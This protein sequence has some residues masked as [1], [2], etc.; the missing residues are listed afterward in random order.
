M[1]PNPHPTNSIEWW[2][3]YFIEHWDAHGGSDQTRHFM[4][5]LI[6]ELPPIERAFL[7]S[8]GVSILDWGCAFGEGVELLARSFPRST[9]TGLD[10]AKTAIEQAGR[11]HPGQR[12]VQTKDGEIPEPFDVIITSN[13]LEHFDNPIEVLHS[14]LDRCNSLYILLVP[15]DESPLSEY[16]RSGFTE[17]SFPTSI[18]GFGRIFVKRIDVEREYWNGQQLLVAYGSEAYLRQRPALAPKALEQEKWD[19]YYSSLP[20]YGADE[21]TQS[22]AVELVE[23]ISELLPNGGRILEAGC[24]GGWQSMALGRSGKFEVH[25]M[26]FSAEALRYARRLFEREGLTAEF[27]YGDVFMPGEPEY[28]LVFN[29][30]VL[31]HYTLDEQARFLRGMASRSRKYVLAMVPN[32]R[33]YWYWLWRIQKSINQ[34]WPFGKEVPLADFSPAFQ[35]SGLQ[36]LG[37]TFM[38]EKWADSF[39]EQVDGISPEL[40]EQL[41]EITHSPLI[42]REQK[43]YLL[44][45]LG[46]VE[47]L[48]QNPPQIWKP[49]P[50]AG[51]DQMAAMHAA[52]A[53]ALA[54]RI[55]EDKRLSKLTAQLLKK[56]RTIETL[57]V[58]IDETERRANESERRAIDSARSDLDRQRESQELASQLS[59][60]RTAVNS[61]TAALREHEEAHSIQ[62]AE[63]EKLVS[64]LSARLA[65]AQRSVDAL[66]AKV[67]ENGTQANALSTQLRDKENALSSLY[68][69]L[70]Q[71]QR[72]LQKITSSLGWRLLTAYGPIKYRY[73]LPIYRILGLPPY[74]RAS[75]KTRQTAPDLKTNIA[76]SPEVFV[77]NFE[78]LR[79]PAE[80]SPQE[81]VDFREILSTKSNTYDVV[82]FPII[83]WDFRFQ[84]PQQLMTRFAS[85]GHRVF[86]LSQSFRASGEPYV[87]FEKLHNVYEVSLRGQPLNVYTDSLNDRSRDELFESLDALRRDFALGATA[88]VVQLPFWWPLVNKT[89]DR[90]SWPVVYDCMDHHA[91]FSTNRPTMIGQEQDLLSSADLVVASSSFLRAEALRKNSSVVVVRNGCEYEHFAKAS[92]WKGERPAIGY[93]GAIADWFD[94]DLVADLAERRPDWDFILV[95][96]TFSADTKRLSRLRNVSL[97]GEQ[98]YSTIP[99]WLR[100]F[101][102]AILPFKRQP[103]TE[104]TNPVK[105]YEILASGKPLISVPIPEMAALE[106]LVGLASTVEEF[107]KQITA[108]LAEEGDEMAQQRRNFAKEN[109]WE[110]RY[111]A[112][113][114]AVCETFAKASIIIVTFNSLE[115]NRL[116]IES[117]FARTDWPNFE[118]IVVDNA[119]SDETPV[120]LRDCEKRFPN[121]H[122]I[123]NTTNLG[124]A[125]ANNIGLEHATG[126]YLVLLNND[127]VVTPGWLSALIRHLNADPTIGLVGPVTNAIA[128]EARIEVGYERIE[129]MESWAANYIR[130]HDSEVFA[131][132]MLAMFCV[133]MKRTLFEQVGPLD[134]RFAVGM[135]EDDDYCRRIRELG[136]RLVCAR[137]SFIH[138]WQRA[139]FRLL[140]ED[141]YLRVYHENRKKYERK[142]QEDDGSSSLRAS[143]VDE[144]YREQLSKIVERVGESKGA[145]IF[146]PSIGWN[147]HLFQRPHHL[148]RTFAANGYVAIFDSSNSHDD[149]KGFKEIEPNLFLFHGPD[150]ILC[151]IPQAILW[152]F[153]YN[154]DRKDAYSP[155]A[156]VV[157]DWIDDLDVFP[158]DRA[159]LER[160]HRR[161]L[162]ESTVVACVARQL[163]EQA[164]TVRPDALYLPNGVEYQR[165]VS[166][167]PESAGDRDLAGFLRDGKPI[168]GYYGALAEWFDYEL[169]DEV[170]RLRPDWNFVLIGQALD[171]SVHRHALT[172]RA[173][174]NWIGPRPYESLPGYLRLFDVATIP[175]K[176]NR[177]TEATSP[178]KL[179][180]YMAGGK[181]II[182]TPMPEC[183]SFPFVNIVRNAQEFALMLDT[184]RTQ[185]LDPE[186]RQRLLATASQ[187]SWAARVESVID[188][189]ELRTQTIR[190]AKAE[191]WASAASP[192]RAGSQ[193][194]AVAAASDSLGGSAMVLESVPADTRKLPA[195]A[196]AL[197]AAEPELTGAAAR[198]AE[199]FRHFK[200]LN[201]ARLF[202]ALARHLAASE[203]DP[204]L[205]MYFEFAITCNERG[206]LAANL[207]QRYTTLQG[208]QYLDVGCAYGGFLVAFAEQGAHVTGMDIDESLLRL[209]RTNLQDNQLDVSLVLADA[210]R[211]EQLKEFYDRV[212][213][214]TCNDVIEHV[215]DPQLLLSNLAATLRAD[216]LAYFEIPNSH[217]PRHVLSDG[218]YQL[219]GITLLDYPDARNY[220][221]LHAPGV[222]YGVRHY[223]SLEQYVQMFARAGLELEVL[224]SNYLDVDLTTTLNDI[225]ELRDHAGAGLEG[226]PQS[227]R[228]RVQERLTKYFREVESCPRATKSEQRA[229]LLRYGMGFWRVL[230]RKKS[231]ARIASAPETRPSTS[232][233]RISDKK[234]SSIEAAHSHSGLCNVCGQ[235][236]SFYYDDPALYRESLVCA[237]CGTTSRYRSIARGILRAI[238][239]LTGIEV[240]SIANLGT[241]APTRT[242]KIYDT[243]ASFYYHAGAYPIPDLLSECK[244]L[245]VQTSLFKPSKRLGKLLGP[246]ITNQNLEALTFADNSFDIVVT[247]D[248]ME[249]VRLDLRAH[250]EVRR[251]LKPGGIYLFTVPH[252]RDRETLYR[253][254]VIDPDDPAKDI[255]LTEKEYHGD[256]NSKDGRALSYRSYGTDLDETLRRLGFSVDYS[257]TDI[258]L[259]GIMNTELFFCRLS[260]Q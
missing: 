143:A 50:S 162:H 67:V 214:I 33:C 229:F 66:S 180:E 197:P 232:P 244:W 46:S 182:T 83:D 128:N 258:P 96:S 208:K 55:G 97:P 91:G 34:D 44:A 249:H 255:F 111:A 12:F 167:Y 213:L 14:H 129:E 35:A 165:F 252:F 94:S 217:T 228:T 62:L 39:V 98:H 60:Q 104:A 170:A 53:D 189:L 125:P 203:S 120:Y 47:H 140:G 88:A 19:Q 105:A 195:V 166:D 92:G 5:R 240:P 202:N 112:L 241:V 57:T 90:F 109:T 164:L 106:P 216:G 251:V 243:Q 212:D 172:G 54:L 78:Q 248:V 73:L 9:V 152:A 230:G 199:H 24:G 219:F 71:K 158:H 69:Q 186:F 20:L 132:Q 245:E 42:P 56:D 237:E 36:F 38:G 40:K 227:L 147:I 45:G 85:D 142:W 231:S 108:A 238:R 198:I 222:S 144:K 37:Q 224:E 21:A 119:S 247:S 4:E 148:A 154:L 58:R 123:L 10:F 86:Y 145:V 134:E 28:D 70:A 7:N 1:R 257:K 30:G 205:A 48:D 113:A 188:T 116:C 160:N 157:Y 169:L 118:V 137:D 161:G 260:K 79:E 233:V 63:H 215:E 122:V 250:Q 135:F 181:P 17:A 127:T 81:F 64:S 16:H 225:K 102:V 151:E 117:V 184:A 65:E 15:Y 139:S 179:Y 114:P 101:D 8:A 254:A 93:Y 149:V 196:P 194:R 138:H 253:V 234:F 175:F 31:E 174:V 236:T 103:L 74:S 156:H 163:H 22:F 49:S 29:A 100:K 259:T 141:E 192:S 200:T 207:L 2:E 220:Y 185:A 51:D 26:D 130:H 173:N 107:E 218:H 82:C 99:K 43:S 235:E 84:R 115:L 136:Y 52:L 41:L 72:E 256:A 242:L 159:L 95:G 206:R 191:S 126:E 89:R 77:P 171:G 183:Q 201:N 131:I 193:N 121:L 75:G 18:G 110:K 27:I 246:K 25:L 153:P 61:L 23:H 226:V 190:P 133:A 146:L 3:E 187:N 68:G 177:I 87:I 210:T 32:L 6:F 59:E 80:P 223:L 239:E 76:T 11:R 150:D 124:F 209:A 178:L 155:G 211:P 176:I 204:C 168:A 221:E 13:C